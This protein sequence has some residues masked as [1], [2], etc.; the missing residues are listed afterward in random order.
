[1]LCRVC[2]AIVYAI[3]HDL[4]HTSVESCWNKCNTTGC[5]LRVSR[6]N[7]GW[8]AAAMIKGLGIVVHRML[9][10]LQQGS[11]FV[12]SGAAAGTA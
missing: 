9:L 12:N 5:A 8:H 2:R 10:L 7:L 1:M 11:R 3:A 4:R 6:S